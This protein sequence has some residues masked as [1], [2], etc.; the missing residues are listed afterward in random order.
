[1]QVVEVHHVVMDVLR[2]DHQVADQ[3]GVLRHLGADGIFDRP[4]GRDAVHERAHAADAL[5]ERPGISR[6]PVAQ[7]NLDTPHHG[8]GR[9]RLRDLV[10]FHLRFD[11]KV[12][13]D[14]RDRVDYDSGVHD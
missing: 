2:A 1:V 4:D 12:T 11:A 3:F 13:F 10:A 7:D 9:I 14:A 8:A 6:I 5:R